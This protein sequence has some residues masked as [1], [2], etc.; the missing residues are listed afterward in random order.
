MNWYTLDSRLVS[1]LALWS[2]IYIHIQQCCQLTLKEIQE[3]LHNIPCTVMDSPN[4]NS[5]KTNQL[6]I[7]HT[8]WNT[9]N[10][11][12]M[13][14]IAHYDSYSGNREAWKWG[15]NAKSSYTYLLQAMEL[16]AWPKYTGMLLLLSSSHSPQKPRVTTY[17][18]YTDKQHKHYIPHH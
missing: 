18:Y 16:S 6:E 4:W 2:T 13:P 11:I 10:I 14:I 9:R 7:F 5:K 15:Y 17:S 1:L 3:C 12:P 8:N